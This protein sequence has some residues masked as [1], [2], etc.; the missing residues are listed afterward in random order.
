V[1][2]QNP[3]IP[4][5]ESQLPGTAE[6]DY[7]LDSVTAELIAASSPP[8]RAL[9]GLLAVSYCNDLPLAPMLSH[10][11][12]EATG[13]FGRQAKY[14]SFLVH[15][16]ED[17]VD[18]VLGLD[19]ILTSSTALKLQVARDNGSLLEFYRAVLERSEEYESN[20][21]FRIND[22]ARSSR[23][24]LKSLFTLFLCIF[25]MTRIFPELSK[26]FEEFGIDFPPLMLLVLANCQRFAK[27]WFLGFFLLI[28]ICIWLFLRY[29]PRWNPVTWRQPV[30]S[31]ASR[32]RRWL[33]IVSRAKT[34]SE[35]G[36][37]KILRCLPGEKFLPKLSQAQN[38]VE[39]GANQWDSL[40]TEGAISKRES[41]ALASTT[42]AD[43]QAW[44]LRWAANAHGDRDQR[45]S[46]LRVNLMIWFGNILL[47]LIVFAF[48]AAIFSSLIQIMKGLQ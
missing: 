11:S 39:G 17:P 45:R 10:L 36:L 8:Q 21:G 13:K 29:L 26:M 25:I 38:R 35:S 19:R 28:P 22:D 43:T 32:R 33:A 24:L 42:S 9:L 48:C 34:S 6:Q 2:S 46:S 14:L 47:A 7:E 5:P 31:N 23:L 3:P 18:A 30:L 27:L 37:A 4:S 1:D 16:G 20:V 44:L 40:A 15:Q 41:K 12:V